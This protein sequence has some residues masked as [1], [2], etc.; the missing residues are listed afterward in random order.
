V[1]SSLGLSKFTHTAIQVGRWPVL[2]I[3]V[4]LALALIYRYGP[5]RCEPKWRWITWGSAFAAACWIVTSF[6]FS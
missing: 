5:S 4:S 2:L 6:L 3:V 1:L